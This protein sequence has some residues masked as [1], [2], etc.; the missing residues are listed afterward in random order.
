[1]TSSISNLCDN[2]AEVIHKIICEYRHDYKQ[3]E[4]CGIK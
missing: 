1:M 2:V 3:C 4:T